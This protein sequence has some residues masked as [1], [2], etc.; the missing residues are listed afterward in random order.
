RSW[1][2]LRASFRIGSSTL[3]SRQDC[4]ESRPRKK[5]QTAAKLKIRLY[6]LLYCFGVMDSTGGEA[7]SY[8]LEPALSASIFEE[9]FRVAFG[10]EPRSIALPLDFSLL[11]CTDVRTDD[12]G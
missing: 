11:F 10:A 4:A 7:K 8:A 9:R 5:V 1:P 2:F 3:P 12:S 6:S